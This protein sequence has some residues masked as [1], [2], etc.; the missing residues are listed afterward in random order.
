[1]ILSLSVEKFVGTYVGTHAALVFILGTIG[2]A[3]AAKARYLDRYFALLSLLWV[4]VCFITIV[5]VPL[6][7]MDSFTMGP[8][9][10]FYPF[11]ILS[12]LLIWIAVV[13]EWHVRVAVA[14]IFIF[15]IMHAGTKLSRRHDAIDWRDQVFACAASQAYDLP[16]HYDGS[17][18]VWHL[19]LT[20]QEC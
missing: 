15:S 1:S 14:L 17:S 16:I 4:G 18:T 5:R 13:S 6:Q 7:G 8:R 3:V 2:I 20:G 12:W 9:Y 11:I 10:F 19:K